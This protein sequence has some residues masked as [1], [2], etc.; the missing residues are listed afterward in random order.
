[1]KRNE[2]ILALF[3]AFFQPVIGFSPSNELVFPT[4]S[5]QLSTS[6]SM[7]GCSISCEQLLNSQVT[8]E[9]KA[10][11]LYLSAS[12][13]CE[14]R[15]LIGMAAYM[16]NE[17][18]E[19]RAHAITIIDFATKRDVRLRLQ[20]IT[21]PESDW[22]SCLDVWKSLLKAEQD[23][24]Q[25]LFR[26]ADAA[27]DSR[28]HALTAFLRPYHMEQVESEDHLETIIS[29]VEDESLTPGLIRQLDTELAI[30]AKRDNSKLAP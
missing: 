21:A 25:S 16:L 20:T 12:I 19:E 4:S 18:D 29:K 24:T 13:W 8:E 26:L 7:T 10:S 28:D 3:L 27:Q 5:K 1:M 11:Q 30:N 6:L 17:S 9:L 15:N 23:T 2:A 22:E 14:E